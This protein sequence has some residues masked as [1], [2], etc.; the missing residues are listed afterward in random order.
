MVISR[1]QAMRRLSSRGFTLIELLVVIAIIAVLIGLLIPASQSAR[2]AAQRS[3]CANNLRQIGLAMHNYE[4][5]FG[6]LPP[7]YLAAAR[8]SDPDSTPGWGWGAMILPFLE[9]QMVYSSI[10]FTFPIDDYASLTVR[11]IRLAVFGCLSV[12]PEVE[13]KTTSLRG[14]LG[15]LLIDR[16]SVSHYVASAD[17]Y[18]LESSPDENVGLF[19]RGSKVSF[20]HITDGLSNSIMAGERS[21]NAVGTWVGVVPGGWICPVDEWKNQECKSA[22]VMPLA[23]VLLTDDPLIIAPPNSERAGVDNYSS[24]HIGGAWFLM[25]DGSGRFLKEKIDATVFKSLSSRSGGEV[26][27]KDTY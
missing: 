11:G 16:L 5:T 20:A 13:S 19:Y 27:S 18:D 22:M 2:Q 10:N 23:R 14:P 21:R 7:G 3:Q 1:S 9:Q 24:Y 15:D 8:A 12:P 17:W 26:I 4:S 25:A 6:C